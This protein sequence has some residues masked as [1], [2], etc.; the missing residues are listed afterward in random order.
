M[1]VELACSPGDLQ[2]W[3]ATVMG[4]ARG[5]PPGGQLGVAWV[6]R[7]RALSAAAGGPKMFGDGTPSSACQ[8]PWQFSCWN[9]NSPEAEFMQSLL[10]AENQTGP[11][12]DACSD[13]VADAQ[14]GIG[15]DPTLG[16]LW[17][18]TLAMGWPAGWGPKVPWTVILGHQAFYAKLGA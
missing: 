15:T 6:I 8:A 14:A 5:E 13:A 11:V 17:Y 9:A 1:M 18:H 2:I 16:S 3:I 10:L 4:E 12:W 7:N